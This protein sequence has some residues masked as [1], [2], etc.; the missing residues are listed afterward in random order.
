MTNAEI[1]FRASVELMK[2]GTIKGTGRI[3]TFTDAAGQEIQLEEPEQIHTYAV[4]QQLGRQVKKGEKA[5]VDLMIWKQGAPR[6]VTVKDDN[7][8]ESTEEIAGSM[9]MKR[10]YFFR[11]D[12][13]EPAKPRE[14]KSKK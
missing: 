11:A 1:I 5:I 4:W 8:Q 14:K 12:Q 10:A 9:F 6:T 7:G 3:F 2:D 13:T